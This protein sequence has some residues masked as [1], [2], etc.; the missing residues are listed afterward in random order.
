M[1]KSADRKSSRTFATNILAVRAEVASA[2]ADGKSR[3]AIVVDVRAQML[4]AHPDW[5]FP[6]WIDFAVR[7]FIA[8]K[9]GDRP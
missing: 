1:A 2:L 5:H 7:Y 3:D 8:V 6:E 4:A 9:D